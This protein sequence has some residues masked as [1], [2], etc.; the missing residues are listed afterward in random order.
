M[1]LGFIPKIADGKQGK[2]QSVLLRDGLGNV[3]GKNEEAIEAK[4]KKS[5]DHYY[6]DVS[7]EWNLLNSKM[8][9]TDFN[10]S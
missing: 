2:Y 3:I 9:L 10:I 1:Y 6:L 7:K 8:F 5:L 4:Q